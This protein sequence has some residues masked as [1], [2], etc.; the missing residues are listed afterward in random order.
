MKNTP[1]KTFNFLLF[2][3]LVA[4]CLAACAL[5][6]FLPPKAFDTGIVYQEF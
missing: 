3:L 6:T 2:F 5:F 1:P 4:A